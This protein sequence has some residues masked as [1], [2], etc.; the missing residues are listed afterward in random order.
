MIVSY[1]RVTLSEDANGSQHT[2]LARKNNG[3]LAT[4]VAQALNDDKSAWG[5]V[6]RRFIMGYAPDKNSSI[7]TFK[8][9]VGHC[10][11]QDFCGE[12]VLHYVVDYVA[13]KHETAQEICNSLS[14]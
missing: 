4:I 12:V 5:L 6:E 14:N 3:G 7:T 9:E 8:P 10:A 2:F 11:V 13:M 1:Y